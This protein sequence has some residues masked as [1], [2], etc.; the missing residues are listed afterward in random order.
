[1]QVHMKTDIGVDMTTETTTNKCL[2]AMKLI[3]YYARINCAEGLFVQQ[4][5]TFN[6]SCWK[7]ARLLRCV[8]AACGFAAAGHAAAQTTALPLFSAS[9]SSVPAAPWRIAGLPVQNKAA[10]A[11]TRYD[12]TSIDG[13]KVLR[14]QTDGSYGNLVHALA[15]VKLA[16]KA[17]LRWSWRLDQPL[18]NADLRQKRGD[19]SPLKVCLL[20]DLPAAKLSFVD[21]SVLS[22]ARS[23]SGEKLPSATLCYV[24]DHRLPEGTLLNNAY[25]SRVRMLVLNSG[26]KRLGQW[27]THQ[28]DV[29]ADFKLAFGL[30]SDSLPALDGVLVGADSDNAGGQSTAYVGDIS[31]GP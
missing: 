6:P 17:Q 21:R 16:E 29:A 8:L 28:R 5:G 27:V 4:S 15:G 31:L 24:W 13:L 23:V 22:L 3:A 11:T 12:I 25:T 30:E 7:N 26:D 1:M 18:T 19:D 10:V 14:V 2:N 9:T 20:F